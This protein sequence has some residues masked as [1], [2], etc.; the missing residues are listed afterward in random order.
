METAIA[1]RTQSK[2]PVSDLAKPKKV[3]K[4]VKLIA[5]PAFQTRFLKREDGFKYEW[6]NGLVEKTTRNRASTDFSESEAR[7]ILAENQKFSKF[8][9]EII[10]EK[11]PINHIFCKMQNYRAAGVQVVWLI[12][13]NLR[14]VHV[15][16]GDSLIDMR[17]C[18]GDALCSAAP[19]LP[20][21]IIS[22]VDILKKPV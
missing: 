6:V 18:L 16:S 14:E 22:V 11:N 10:S 21:F 1:V 3:G 20:D 8:I 17:V 4:E 19:V 9:I 15:F 12:F 7:L 5:W 13:P 2:N